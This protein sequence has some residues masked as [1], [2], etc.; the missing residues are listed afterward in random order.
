M[1]NRNSRIFAV[2]AAALL[3]TGCAGIELPTGADM[4]DQP[5]GKSTL[6]VGMTRDQVE[7]LWGKPDEK[8]MV[9]NKEKWGGRRELWVYRGRLGSIPVDVDY[10]SRTK[11]LY[12]D[13]E[14]LTTIEDIK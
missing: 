13:D 14:Y 12:F 11:K 10:L 9:E 7:S 1:R 5:L 2:L 8:R 3:M 6:K 4:K